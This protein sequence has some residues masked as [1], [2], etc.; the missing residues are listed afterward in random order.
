MRSCQ[1]EPKSGGSGTIACSETCL[2]SLLQEL[3]ASSY[4]QGLLRHEPAALK[5]LTSALI[6]NPALA[7]N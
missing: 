2:F 7:N 1:A 6:N 3:Q 4:Y 5:A